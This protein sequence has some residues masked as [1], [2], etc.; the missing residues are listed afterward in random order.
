GYSTIYRFTKTSLRGWDVEKKNGK[1]V[2]SFVNPE[3][4]ATA[5]QIGDEVVALKSE[6]PEAMPIVYSEESS[7]WLTPAGTGYTLT[8]LRSGQ[9]LEIPLQS[10]RQSTLGFRL[11]FQA[12]FLIFAITGLTIFLSKHDDKQALLLALMLGSFVG[13]TNWQLAGLP[14]WIHVIVAIARC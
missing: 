14:I 7:Y 4:P 1:P 3:G 5:L 11:V 2:I 10:M 8:V 12:I 13:V 9:S 6:R